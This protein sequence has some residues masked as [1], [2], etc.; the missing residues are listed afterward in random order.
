V[1]PSALP[2]R[3]LCLLLLF[4]Y[5]APAEAGLPLVLEV[6]AS[7][8]Q[9]PVPEVLSSSIW[10]AECDRDPPSRIER[11]FRENDPRTVMLTLTRVLK[12]S[13]GLKDLDRRLKTFFAAGTGGAALLRG[14]RRHGSLL[15]VGFDPA[16][17]PRW[18]SSRPGRRDKAYRDQPFYVEEL[19]PPRDLSLWAEAVRRTLG[20][21][22]KERGIER[23]GLYVGHE[24]NWM[25]LGSQR[26]FFD[27]YAAAARAA[28]ALDPTIQVG[29]I[30]TWSVDAVKVDCDYGPFRDTIRKACREEGGWTD[31]APMI[32]SF[33]DY[34]VRNK[35]PLD[36]VNWHVFHGTASRWAEDV[37]RLRGWLRERGLSVR[38]YPAD[39]TYWQ[40]AGAYPA[41]YLDTAETAAYAVET[42]LQLWALGVDWH[43]YDFDVRNYGAEAA[44]V[45][46][47]R[48]STFI[49]DWSVMTRDGVI[50]P[51]YNAFRCLSMAVG[52]DPSRRA[53]LLGVRGAGEM[54]SA[55]A[56]VSRDRR[57]VRLLLVH[58][59]PSF[60]QQRE[61]VAQ[62]ILAGRLGFSAEDAV[63]RLG[64]R[65]AAA[66]SDP[67][68]L[69]TLL[70][71]EKDPARRELI[72][73]LLDVDRAKACLQRYIDGDTKGFRR[74]RGK[75]EGGLSTPAVRSIL[76]AVAAKQG[77]LELRVN[78]ENLPWRGRVRVRTYTV[79]RDHANACRA[80]KATEPWRNR[81]Y[82]AVG[83]IGGEIDRALW[84]GRSVE[85]VNA[86]ADVSLEGSAVS[87]VFE[88]H[89]GSLTLETT[90]Q[91]NAVRL[92]VLNGGTP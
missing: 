37:R 34:V 41:S 78:F 33:L 50:K 35:V 42:L 82:G 90:L 7:A 88:A 80:S 13:S 60:W 14:V 47:M 73:T 30:G 75:V 40:G 46:K 1:K 72:Q 59:A 20:Y 25:W 4:F 51:L 21:L 8:V 81:R 2:R 36:F 86:R 12:D 52:T 63:R 6:D 85:S 87:R 84:E 61:T 58:F 10:V 64:P 45:E 92:V 44:A 79:D 70:G 3:F 39:W 74:C 83:G 48:G 22:R 32:R 27:T 26:S 55:L 76:E 77:P 17:M 53:D 16:A 38:L 56:T 28:K 54:V 57:E 29:G 69:R 65:R 66:L 89:G 19:S 18:L 71:G 5:A 91:P 9:G 68:K 31:G 11:F 23:L 62:R 24:P 43:G 15:V 67:R 49:G